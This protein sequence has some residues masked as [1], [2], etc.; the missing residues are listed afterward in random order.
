MRNISTTYLFPLINDIL[1]IN[2][3]FYSKYVKTTY[4]NS[5]LYKDKQY[6]YI[7]ID[8]DFKIP[9]FRQEEERLMNFDIFIDSVDVDEDT[10]L[11]IYEF[12]KSYEK[13]FEYFKKGKYSKFGN[14][15]KMKILK[16]FHR[17]LGTST[18]G[19]KIL[20]KIKHVLYRNSILKEQLEESLG[21][22]LNTDAELGSI[23]DNDKETVKIDKKKLKIENL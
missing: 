13:E 21:I 8:Y 2:Y 14:D 3:N 11:M 1:E 4:I 17:L 7:L 22:K 23:M 6:F 10:V 20:T 9:E 18:E 16:F 15:A 12:P 19:L 5:D